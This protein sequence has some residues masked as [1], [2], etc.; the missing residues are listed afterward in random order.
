MK[1]RKLDSRDLYG[2]NTTI[3]TK[4][5]ESFLDLKSNKDYWRSVDNYYAY[6]L[7]SRIMEI[8]VALKG[9]GVL[10]DIHKETAL[11][12]FDAAFE[13][14]FGLPWSKA[15]LIVTATIVESFQTGE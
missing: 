8:F 7:G 2:R 14:I 4:F 13:S 3:T 1:W 9:P 10:L 5:M 12:G 11:N 6:N 15:S